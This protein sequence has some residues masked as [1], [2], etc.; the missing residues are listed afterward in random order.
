MTR[1]WSTWSILT[2]VCLAGCNS[3]V[4]E[5]A[6]GQQR[7]LVGPQPEHMGGSDHRFILDV[8]DAYLPRT[9]R[10]SRTAREVS[11]NVPFVAKLSDFSGAGAGSALAPGVI[12]GTISWAPENF[13]KR[14]FDGT[15][16]NSISQYSVPLGQRYGLEV[17]TVREAKWFPAELYINSSPRRSVM[18]ECA[19]MVADRPQL[20]QMWSQ[21]PGEPLVKVS[22]NE[23]DLQHWE[24]MATGTQGL[25]RAWVRPWTK[26]GS[27]SAVGR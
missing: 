26:T 6:G 21:S 24:R 7:F 18:I 9:Y 20:C 5:A 13:V 2:V 11:S 4:T 16:L 17:R 22:F 19:Y 27:G 25:M 15:W 23:H 1:R 12:S 8:P 10:P 14:M 3:Q